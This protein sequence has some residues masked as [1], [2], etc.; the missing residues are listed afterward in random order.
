MIFVYHKYSCFRALDWQMLDTKCS[1]VLI[2]EC[3][4][5][6]HRIQCEEII[7]LLL[8]RGSCFPVTLQ[9]NQLFNLMFYKAFTARSTFINTSFKVLELFTYCIIALFQSFYYS[10]LSIGVFPSFLDVFSNKQS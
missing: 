4:L 9:K 1:A 5:P 2:V 8:N 3:L 6:D 10:C 7:Y